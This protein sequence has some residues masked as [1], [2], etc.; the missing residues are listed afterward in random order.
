MGNS[1]RTMKTSLLLPLFFLANV[2]M[3]QTPIPIQVSLPVYLEDVEFTH[4]HSPDKPPIGHLCG[5][6]LYFFDTT[7]VREKIVVS[8]L[9][10]P[11]I[12]FDKVGISTKVRFVMADSASVSSIDLLYANRVC[13]VNILDNDQIIASG[14][15]SEEYG[16]HLMRLL[17]EE[18]YTERVQS[19]LHT[20]NNYLL[21]LHSM[22]QIDIPISAFFDS[23]NSNVILGKDPSF[24][25]NYDLHWFDKQLRQRLKNIAQMAYQQI[26]EDESQQPYKQSIETIAWCEHLAKKIPGVHN[27]TSGKVSTLF[28]MKGEKEYLFLKPEQEYLIQVDYT[29]EHWQPRQDRLLIDRFSIKNIENNDFIEMEIFDFTW[30]GV[31]IIY[32]DLINGVVMEDAGAWRA[33][34]FLTAI[35]DVFKLVRM[36]GE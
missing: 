18:S 6:A 36:P 1:L 27:K 14:S 8:N 12:W 30:L 10:D 4:L 2:A 34:Q 16:R 22:E 26:E 15:I 24:D 33:D 3:S 31:P 21:R 25:T 35:Q 20:L 23:N 7:Q 9:H 29:Y 11:V 17:G 28:K 5:V 32:V 13:T 19:I